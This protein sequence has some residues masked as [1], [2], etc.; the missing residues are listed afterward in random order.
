M[1]VAA[2]G[3]QPGWSRAVVLSGALFYL[4]FGGGVTSTSAMPHVTVPTLF[5]VAEG[6]PDSPIAADQ[7]L[8]ATAPPGVVQ[9]DVL[10]EGG[11]G[12]SLLQ[13]YPGGPFAPLV[14]QVAAFLLA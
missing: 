11:H 2:A 5:A 9:L 14:D 4:D 12:W 3:S 13:G 8:V 7:A 10:P 6:D 1:A